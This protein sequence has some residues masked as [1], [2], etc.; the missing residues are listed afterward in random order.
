VI[1]L[2]WQDNSQNES[3]F[4]VERKS[5][6][7]EFAEID[8]TNENVTEYL[9]TGLN[10]NTEYT[11]RVRAT[12]SGGNS[13]YSN[14]ASATTQAGSPGAPTDLT[15]TAVTSTRINLTWDDN[16]ANETG[17]EIERK[18]GSGA[19]AL[20]QTTAAGATSFS[21]TGLT[22][23]TT[24]TYRVR[25]KNAGGN[26]GY[27]NEASATTPAAPTPP[28]APS[29]L[30]AAAPTS[31][32]VNLAWRDNSN[33]E[34]GFEV[35]RK[36]GS[37]AFV[38]LSTTAA[39]ATSLADRQVQPNTTYTYRVRASNSG[40]KSAYSNE[41]TVKTPAL[42]APP[43]APS[44]LTV[45]AAST[46]SLRLT[47]QDN[48]NN[49]E[50]FEIE[51]RTGTG[52]F[53][54]IFTAPP[55]TKTHLDTGLQA[56]R[57][58]RYRVR[59][60]N[61]GGASAYSNEGSSYTLPS[62]PTNLTVAVRVAAQLELAW[63]DTNPEPAAHQVERAAPGSSTFTV[64]GSAPAGRA[65]FVDTGLAANTTYRYR[66]RAVNP[67]GTSAYSNI[68]TG[69]TQAPLGGQLSVA[70]K[71]AFGGVKVRRTTTRALL[72][73]NLSTT[74]ALRVDVATP[75]SPFST[76]GT[77][78]VSILPPLG[79]RTVTLSF[80]PTVKRQFKRT[81]LIRSSDP[82]KPSVRVTLVGRGK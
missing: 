31:D 50:R 53:T 72:I 6:E 23:S 59:A 29:L 16:S 14:E 73:R 58:Y 67:A 56:N 38:L 68:A 66:V 33:N 81:L 48:S 65:T 51:R 52:A 12:N 1:R 47:W 44:A 5:G 4:K 3:G 35:E 76:V 43:T 49:E 70:S 8:Q 30:T 28:A 36:V 80:R 62:A 78:G 39:N 71:V 34:E 21:N 7:D 32:R 2:E 75:S 46:S 24:Y 10:G 82:T 69:T 64:V 45:T 42:P 37:G 41:A 61:A 77:G 54:R 13:A 18:T 26:S 79:S 20:I 27:S 19:F 25:A 17:F 55:N 57:L 63:R 74:Q 40:G 11:Y 22:P 60:L 15:A 9:D